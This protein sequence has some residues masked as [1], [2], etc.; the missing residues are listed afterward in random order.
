[1]LNININ[2]L[3]IKK[4]QLNKTS[5]KF[6]STGVEDFNEN[7]D[8]RAYGEVV[9]YG[10]GVAWVR[11]LTAV[12]M[13][14]LIEFGNGVVGLVLSLESELLGA[15]VL[16]EES[17]IKEG[18]IATRR[19]TLARVP[20]GV[21]LCGRVVDALGTPV[22]N[23]G[24]LNNTRY[25]NVEVKAPGIIARQKV[26]EPMQT[27]ILAIDSIF[28][29]GRGQRELI[30]GDRQMG[31]TTIAVD[32]IVNQRSTLTESEIESDIMFCIYVAVGQ[33]RSGI[34]RLVK[35]LKDENAM[36]FTTVVTATASEPAALQFLA[37]YA[38]AAIGEYF[39][40][41]GQDALIVYDDLS[42]HAVAYRQ[43]SLLLNRPPGREAYPGDVFYLHS[44]LL[45][46]AAKLSDD[47]GAGS[48]TAL[49]IIETQAG[50]V[51]GYIPTNV[52]SI[53][54]GQIFLDNDLFY[55]NILPA[56]NIGL[57]VSRIGSSAQTAAM[58]AVSGSL[59]L[60]LALFKEI[61]AFTLMDADID[62]FTRSILDRGQKLTELLKQKP[63]QT[64]PLEFQII[65]VYAGTQGYLNT[66]PLS[67]IEDLKQYVIKDLQKNYFDSSFRLNL[68]VNNKT[69]NSKVVDYIKAVV[70][71]FSNK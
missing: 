33:R 41:S 51:S 8:Y 60:N 43:I 25:A 11:G 1:M 26:T 36:F 40:D 10:D 64:L 16:G 47:C 23:L 7:T 30:I 19:G 5:I 71:N 59:K 70:A 20:V 57:S 58:K 29:I 28:P 62:D 6:F 14:E 38:G 22:D 44:R 17:S 13:G 39:R 3:I 21:E 63:F 69:L 54:D 31:K 2:K 24:S 27:G 18:D 67:R 66:V 55:S 61:E 49:P 50:D 52:I 35:K 15:V 37:P 32:S 34:A 9:Y 53:T 68:D 48:L 45:E 12:G 4:N 65:F 56:I 42:K 46:R